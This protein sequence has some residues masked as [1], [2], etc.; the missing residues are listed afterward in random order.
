VP[1]VEVHPWSAEG[2]NPKL[3]PWRAKE[4]DVAYEW[5]GGK[6]NYLSVNAFYMWLDTWI[7]K[8]AL[9][10][11][12]SGFPLPPGAASIPSDVPIS[13][14]GYLTAPANGKGGWLRGV[15]LSGAFEFGRLAKVLDGFGAQ[16]S[17]SYTDYY[18]PPQSL[19]DYG[20]VLPGFSKWV[21][22]ITGYYEKNGFQ[23]RAS[24]RYRS[25]FKGEVPLLWTN[26]GYPLILADKQLDAQ[27]GYTF[28]DGSRLKGLGILLQINNLLNSPY[29]TAYTVNGT[30]TL[31]NFEKFGRQWM[32]GASYHF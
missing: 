13:P 22:N 24:Y 16:G 31:E 23:A 27:V 32:L 26:L 15:E 28:Q 29:R 1:G 10:V 17:V 25:R 14:I 12:F 3:R 6:A 7:Y 2:G 4:L 21:Y 20:G 19:T 5:Y 30:T 8:Q 11:D 18:L 9:Q